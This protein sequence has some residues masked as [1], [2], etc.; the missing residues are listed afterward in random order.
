MGSRDLPLAHVRRCTVLARLFCAELGLSEIYW[1]NLAR[2]GRVVV[3]VL[4]ATSALVAGWRP[5][6]VYRGEYT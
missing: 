4:S 6:R 3:L 1:L 5:H 2:P